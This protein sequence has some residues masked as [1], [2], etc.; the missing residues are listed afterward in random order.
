MAFLGI[1]NW[2]HDIIFGILLVYLSYL[3]HKVVFPI[4]KDLWA[5]LLKLVLV[6]G[7]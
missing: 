1:L 5:E 2:H 4:C 3:C 7:K 6:L